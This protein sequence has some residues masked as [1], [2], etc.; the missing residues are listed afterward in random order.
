[1]HAGAQKL[2]HIADELLQVPAAFFLAI[3]LFA[4]VCMQVV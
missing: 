4:A 3:A 1:V 2:F